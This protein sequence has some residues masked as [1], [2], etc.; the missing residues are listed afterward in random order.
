MGTFQSILEIG[1]I[2]QYYQKTTSK[3]IG[4]LEEIANQNWI[5]KKNLKKILSKL[6]NKEIKIT[7]H[8]YAKINQ[9]KN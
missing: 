9:D 6:K 3:Y 7:C 1:N 4:L 2:I 5:S 8:L